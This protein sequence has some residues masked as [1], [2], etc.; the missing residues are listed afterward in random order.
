M[1]H[2]DV[3]QYLKMLSALIVTEP[4]SPSILSVSLTYLSVCV[5]YR[6][7]VCAVCMNHEVVVLQSMTGT[8]Q[9]LGSVTRIYNFK[10]IPLA[11]PVSTVSG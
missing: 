8:A 9:D 1:L 2:I 10:Y 11:P 5:C 6:P 4:L 7:Q 3:L